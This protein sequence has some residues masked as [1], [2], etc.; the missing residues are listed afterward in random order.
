MYALLDEGKGHAGGIIAGAEE[1]LPAGSSVTMQRLGPS[2][3]QGRRMAQ[4]STVW[5][6]TAQCGTA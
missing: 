3:G 2:C 6:G 4:H 5:H 1:E